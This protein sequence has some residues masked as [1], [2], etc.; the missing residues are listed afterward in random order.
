[1]DGIINDMDVFRKPAALETGEFL[2][3]LAPYQRR[4]EHPFPVASIGFLPRK[5]D[6][7]NRVFDT[8]NFSFILAGNGA[9]TYDNTVLDVRA[10]CVL[11][12]SPGIPMDYGPETWWTELFLIYAAETLETLVQH[13]LFTTDRPTWEFALTTD[14]DEHLRLLMRLIPVARDPFAVDRIDRVC[15]L[16]LVETLADRAPSLR[17]PEETMVNT[18]ARQMRLDILGEHTVE[19]L[20]ERHN[21]HPATFRRHWNRYMPSPPGR[22]LR[23]LRV[24]EACRRLA[25]TQRPISEIA[26]ELGFTDPLYFSRVFRREIGCTATEYRERHGSMWYP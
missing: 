5:R 19:E 23:R 8:Q 17:S 12:Q 4:T 18:A 13:R 10:P 21:V 2:A 3:H 22:Y 6:R 26:I 9:Y 7:V 15:E 20:A 14:F 24:E 11:T 16:L 1:M 25:E